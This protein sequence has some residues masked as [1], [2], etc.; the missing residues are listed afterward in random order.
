MP[1]VSTRIGWCLVLLPTHS[2]DTMLQVDQTFTTGTG[3][4][5][6]KL[7]VLTSKHPSYTSLE[8]QFLSAWLKKTNGLAVERIIKVEVRTAC[9]C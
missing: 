5:I 9:S 7:S 3:T 8:K 6:F 4:N 2:P 1:S